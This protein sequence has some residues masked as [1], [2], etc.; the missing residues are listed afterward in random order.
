MAAN[1]DSLSIL[2]FAEDPG[3]ANYLAPLV[4]D[5]RAKGWQVQLCASGFARKIFQDRKVDFRDV[6]GAAD[7]ETLLKNAEVRL[8]LVGTAENK[9]SLGL[10]LVDAAKKLKIPS[11]GVI[12][13]FMNARFRFSGTSRSPRAH[14][15]DYLFVADAATKAE[16]MQLGF[17]AATIFAVGHPHY[18]FVA[19]QGKALTLASRDEIRSRIFP[20]AKAAQLIVA[21]LDEGSAR[22]NSYPDM[23]KENFTLRGFKNPP[24][25]TELVLEEFLAAAKKTLPNAHI[26]FRLH[27]KDTAEDFAAYKEDI[28][29][30]NSGGS[31]LE[32]VYAADLVVGSTTMLLLEAALLGART[33]SIVPR[34][35]EGEWLPCVR[36]GVTPLASERE[37]I[38]P[39]L[40]EAMSQKREAPGREDLVPLGA[41][42]AAAKFVE[43][44]VG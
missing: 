34:R 18:D 21:F 16:F 22:L 3:A 19:E 24:G 33:L 39:A 10:A 2:A 43:I 29:Q 25:R 15:P 27:P 40:R 31:A 8:L 30:W 17:P 5:F 41:V 35:E 32:M 36:A 9:K 37:E 1:K 26:V 28:H 42:A 4:L 6:E 20:Q 44:V 38:A 23:E 14:A 7:A 13:A 12:D 11:I